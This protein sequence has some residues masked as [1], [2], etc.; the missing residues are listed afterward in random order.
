MDWSVHY[1]GAW[2]EASSGETKRVRS[3]KAK[4]VGFTLGRLGTK[5]HLRSEAHCGSHVARDQGRGG[6]G[7]QVQS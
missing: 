4:D 3:Q 2:R 7:R 5:E 1:T 6:R